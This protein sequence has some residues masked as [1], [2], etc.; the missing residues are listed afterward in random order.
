MMEQQRVEQANVNFYRAMHH[1][2][3]DI[4]DAVW[5]HVDWVQCIHPGWEPLTGWNKI[6]QSWENIFRNTSQMDIHPSEV[7]IYADQQF[8]WM[9][10]L[11]INSTL[12]GGQMSIGF[13]QATNIFKREGSDWK[14]VHHHSSSLPRAIP[15]SGTAA[16][17]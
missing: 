2:S 10:C 7:S 13:A 6:C 3:T 4:M 17:P 15:L 14:M 5:L 1:L 12:T 9:T 11:E 16:I 8:A